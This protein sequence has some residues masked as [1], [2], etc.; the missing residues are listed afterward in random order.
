[1]K[2]L[3]GSHEAWDIVDNGYDEPENEGALNQAQ[4]KNLLKARKQDQ[5]ALS[6]IHMG[7]DKDMFEKVAS[8]TRAKEAWEI[9]QNNFKGV[10]KLKRVRLQTLHGKFE[11]WFNE[12]VEEKANL[13]ETEEKQENGVLLMAYKDVIPGDDILWYLDS[14][15]SKHMSGLKHL[16]TDLKEMDSRFVSFGDLS[17][18]EVKG[19]GDIC[20]CQMDGRQ[21]KIE[22]VYYVPNMKN[23]IL[24]LG[25]L[26]EKGYSIF[27][28]GKAMILKEKMA[29][30]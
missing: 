9:L 20:F 22:D 4:K 27:M 3:L 18:I 17:K 19:K 23:N 7:L 13:A 10:N 15:A 21:G 14:G 2:A 16:F 25:Q 12:N 6:F 8:A 30:L 26:L 29:G 1:M 11:S 28:E 5:H 24:S